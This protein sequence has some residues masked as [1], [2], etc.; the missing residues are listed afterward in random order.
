MKAMELKVWVDGV[1]RI[2][3]GVTEFTTCQEVVIALA[4]AIGKV[5]TTSAV[6]VLLALLV[7][8]L[9]ILKQKVQNP[10]N[11]APRVKNLHQSG[12]NGTL[13]SINPCG[14]FSSSAGCQNLQEKMNCSEMKSDLRARRDLRHRCANSDESR[15]S[16]PNVTQSRR[17]VAG[18]NCTHIF[19]HQ[20]QF[21]DALSLL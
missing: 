18:W 2:V 10:E 19:I 7:L 12:L 13:S 5:A 20:R 9:T 8:C 3:C 14:G 6:S 15:C 4:Q 16:F 17:S 1:Q 21:K 11:P